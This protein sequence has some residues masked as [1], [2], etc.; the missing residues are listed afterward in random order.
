MAN[1]TSIG[2]HVA[3]NASDAAASP[4]ERVPPATLAAMIQPRVMGGRILR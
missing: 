2:T 1:D 4:A 3:R